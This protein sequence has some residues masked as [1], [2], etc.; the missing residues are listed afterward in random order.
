M[1]MSPDE[2]LQNVTF[3]P[4]VL[5]A[6]HSGDFQVSVT[7][8]VSIDGHLQETFAA[9]QAFRVTG[10]RFTLDPGHVSSVYPPAGLLGDFDRQ[11]AHVVLASATLPWQ[12]SP[13]VHGKA[14]QEN[15]PVAS[16]LAVLL[17]DQ[18]DP[19]PPLQH[20]RRADLRGSSACFFP[21]LPVEHGEQDDDPVS[22]IEVPV[23]LFNAIAPSRADLDWNAHVR[24]V[25]SLSK[26][27]RDGALPPLDY[28]V[29]VGNRLPRR[30]HVSTAHLV[31]LER[32]A[33]YLPL[34]G[35]RPSPQLPTGTER[36]RL[37]SL[38]SWSFSAL[39]R[40]Q[41]FTDLFRHLDRTP[42]ALQQPWHADSAGNDSG[43]DAVRQAFGLGY[44]A[45]DHDLRDGSRSV[46]W[47]RG[48]LL[49]VTNP[50]ALSPPWRNADALLRYDPAS[51][52]LDASYS[53]AWQLGR[54]LALHDSAFATALY[55]WKLTRTQEQVQALE[56]EIFEQILQP[57]IASNEGLPRQRSQQARLA[58]LLTRLVAPA[59]DGLSTHLEPEEP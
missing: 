33:D 41:S 54:L 15:E 24:S 10:E 45:L 4:Y 27:S 51:G 25:E 46:S 21:D 34:A 48:P 32:Y 57:V 44:T 23:A 8:Q 55:R 47:Y 1:P 30:G 36:V 16:W 20:L 14:P 19:F 58:A 40:Q 31:S 53:A 43:D 28:A 38:K 22:V 17:F 59:V 49:P 18:D 26:A 56:E 35:G 6:L 3:V 42:A 52:L 39:D 9:R 5:P 7:Q 50:L 37:V 12:R 2:R 13:L 29:V 11:L